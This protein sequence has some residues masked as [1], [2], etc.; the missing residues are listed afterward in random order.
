MQASARIGLLL[1]HLRRFF[2]GLLLLGGN[3]AV[4][5]ALGGQVVLQHVDF[6]KAFVDF[7]LSVLV[8]RLQGDAAQVGLGQ[9]GAFLAEFTVGLFSLGAILGLDRKS[10]RL[11]SSH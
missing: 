3:Y 10:T 1:G 7:F 5:L 6:I 4:S 2:L 8:L 9:I 11:N